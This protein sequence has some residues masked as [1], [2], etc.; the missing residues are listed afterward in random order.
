M[1]ACSRPICWSSRPRCPRT[2]H[3]ALAGKGENDHNVPGSCGTEVDNMRG[4]DPDQEG[5]PNGGDEVE[6]IVPGSCGAED[7]N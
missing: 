1:R 3:A 7:D 4:A 2:A 5:G 6:N